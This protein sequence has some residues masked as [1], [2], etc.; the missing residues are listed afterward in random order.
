MTDNDSEPNQDY[1]EL[2][3]YSGLSN[4]V[5]QIHRV[6]SVDPGISTDRV[7]VNQFGELAGIDRLILSA[8]TASMSFSYLTAN[9]ANEEALGFNV[10]G[11]SSSITKILNKTED[12]KNYFLRIA[13]EG[14][15]AV[16]DTTNVGGTLAVGN[17][18]I[19]SYTAFWI[20]TGKH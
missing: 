13:S 20:V 3:F 6:Q 18:F 5:T 2:D 17:G 12:E 1:I 7:D 19:T 16:G 4:L 8:P 14:V 15:D 10:S 9:M 11:D